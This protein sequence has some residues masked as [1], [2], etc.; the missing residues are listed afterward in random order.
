TLSAEFFTNNVRLAWP[1][2]GFG[3]TYEIRHF[4]GSGDSSNWDNSSVILRTT[5]LQADINPVSIGLTTGSHT[6][7]IKSLDS[8]GNY[9]ETA[10]FVDITIPQIPASDITATVVSNSVLLY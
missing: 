1:T 4:V 9:S 8:D 5:S 7:L 3:V 2:T 6:F 10:S